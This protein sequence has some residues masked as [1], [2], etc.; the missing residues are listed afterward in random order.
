[1]SVPWVLELF[2]F[3]EAENLFGTWVLEGGLAIDSGPGFRAVAFERATDSRTAHATIQTRVSLAQIVLDLAVNAYSVRRTEAVEAATKSSFTHAAGRTR[4]RGA[5]G[6][7]DFTTRACE[8]PWTRAC[9]ANTTWG[10]TCS[11]VLAWVCRAAC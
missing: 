3:C 10:Q 5:F 8:A 6:E 4:A 1:M 2:H 7:T 9:E 11:A